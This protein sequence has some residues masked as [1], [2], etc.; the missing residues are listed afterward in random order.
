[1]EGIGMILLALLLAVEMA[2]LVLSVMR[3]CG[4]S[5]RQKA[6]QSETTRKDIL[7]YGL[8]GVKPNGK[9]KKAK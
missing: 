5:R 7:R 8:Y 4:A 6:Q 1:M 3:P 2:Q 9:T